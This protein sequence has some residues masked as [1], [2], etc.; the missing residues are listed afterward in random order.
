[1]SAALSKAEEKFLNL[2]SVE[3][4]GEQLVEWFN[5]LQDTA[6]KPKQCQ[7]NV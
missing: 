5:R 4:E 6:S 1:V 7:C 3:N 2:F